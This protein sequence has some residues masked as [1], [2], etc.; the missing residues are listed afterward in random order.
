MCYLQYEE[1]C[2]WPTC[3]VAAA[4]QG[5]TELV[6]A[7]PRLRKLTLAQAGFNVWQVGECCRLATSA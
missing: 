6:R 3:T 7:S 2:A 1:F 4:D 5:L